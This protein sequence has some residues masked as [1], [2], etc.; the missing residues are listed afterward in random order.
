LGVELDLGAYL[1]GERQRRLDITVREKVLA[2]T[3]FDK[4]H[5]SQ[6]IVLVLTTD[7]LDV[8]RPLTPNLSL[9]DTI[10][11]SELGISDDNRKLGAA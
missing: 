8:N 10:S 1:V 7:D 11:P 5:P 2:E 3:V 9:P 6:K 4:S